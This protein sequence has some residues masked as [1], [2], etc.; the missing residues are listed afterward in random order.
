[1]M[2]TIYRLGTAVGATLALLAIANTTPNTVSA[3]N[4]TTSTHHAASLMVT[5]R[6]I[7]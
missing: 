3:D 1:M 7:P 5:T 4:P 2:N 6:Q